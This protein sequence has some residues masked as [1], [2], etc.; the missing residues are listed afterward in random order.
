MTFRFPNGINVES[1]ST[2]RTTLPPARGSD[3]ND[4]ELLS[5]ALIVIKSAWFCFV[6]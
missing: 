4:N 1:R 5:E 3:L 6:N 2:F